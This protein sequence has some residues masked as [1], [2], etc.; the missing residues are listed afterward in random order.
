MAVCEII[1][2]VAASIAL[3]VYHSMRTEYVASRAMSAGASMRIRGARAGIVPR[4]GLPLLIR[5]LFHTESTASLPGRV[6]RPIRVIRG[7]DA[8]P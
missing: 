1:F 2:Q 4:L 8:A 7:G 5:G 3:Q 6:F